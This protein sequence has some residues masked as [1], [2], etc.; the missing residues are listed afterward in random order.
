MSCRL[1]TIVFSV[2]LSPLPLATISLVAIPSTPSGI[3][4][5]P[6]T[7]QPWPSWCSSAG[8]FHV[9]G[10]SNQLYNVSNPR[11]RVLGKCKCACVSCWPAVAR[12]VHDRLP[13][14]LPLRN[15][16]VYVPLR[17][18]RLGGMECI[19]KSLCVVPYSLQ[20]NELY[21]T[22]YT[23]VGVV[24]VLARRGHCTIP[25][26]QV[27]AVYNFQTS[28]GAPTSRCKPGIYLEACRK[29]QAGSR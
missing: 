18:S 28:D 16:L 26:Q 10:R 5:S 9:L 20:H 6:R 29:D 13:P 27:R 21:T 23:C 8:V 3:P 15:L 11:L 17:F 14:F 24:T 1:L 19:G 12:E 2:P 22:G 4:C 25:L 7:C